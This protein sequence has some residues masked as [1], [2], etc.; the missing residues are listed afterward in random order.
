L[1]TTYYAQLGGSRILNTNR[2]DQSGADDGDVTDWSKD[3]PI[4]V[5]ACIHSNSKDTPTAQYKLRWRNE[6]DSP[7]GAFTDLSA[8]GECK[9]GSTD[10]LSDG[11]DL[12]EVN[13][14]TSTQ[15]DTWQNGEEVEGSTLSDAIDLADDYE[16][17]LQFAVSLA[18]GDEG[19]Q[20]TFDLYDYTN[21]RQVG[22]LGAQITLGAAEVVQITNA[23][24]SQTGQSLG[25]NAKTQIAITNAT[26]AQ[27]GQALGVNAKTLIT[28]S[29]AA[30][31]M[32]GQALTILA[33]EIIAITNAAMLQTGQALT[34]NQQ[35]VVAIAQAAISQVGQALNVNQEEAIQIVNAAISQ[36][37][38]DLTV[39][40]AE[41]MP[42]VNASIS[43]VG[44]GVIVNEETALIISS[45]V[46]SQVGQVLNIN[47]EEVI[48]L[49]NA[50]MSI[51]GQS[52]T[53]LQ[54]GE[55]PYI[56]FG[57]RRLGQSQKME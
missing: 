36:A 39:L 7:G 30:M 19:D 17:E 47:A 2:V 26:M 49:N 53:V 21:D 31:S 50:V 34:V 23:T 6:T 44:Q 28:I 51:V 10:A 8:S 46:M 32:V 54:G 14:R 16:S 45:A 37:G 13:R 15:G 41:I 43:Q 1:T 48:L 5:A 25:V 56:D 38:Q 11:T 55:E 57:L 12:T 27:A 33:A 9:F 40:A 3:D 42:I 29:P 4:I 22:V 20:Y 52:L 35:E 18:D 24:M